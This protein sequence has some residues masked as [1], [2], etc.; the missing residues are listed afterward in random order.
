MK[1]NILFLGLCSLTFVA[2]AQ[3]DEAKIKQ[4]IKILSSDS[5]QGRGVGSEGEKMAAAYIESQFKKLKLQ[6]KG[7]NNDFRQSFPFKGGVHGTGAEGTGNNLIAFLDNKAAY[8]VIIG[9]H[10]DHLGLGE[11]G[12]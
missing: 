9:A 5:L 11:N 1:F 3:L 12:R 8:T 2:C 10:Y 7:V 6:P 4:H